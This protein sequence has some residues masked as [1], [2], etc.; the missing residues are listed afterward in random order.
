MRG[1]LF[2]IPQGVGLVNDFPC[3]SFFHFLFC[4]CLRKLLIGG[5]RKSENTQA[6]RAIWLTQGTLLVLFY[7]RQPDLGFPAGLDGDSLFI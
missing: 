6:P 4:S 5:N 1:I 3:H 2:S 7:S